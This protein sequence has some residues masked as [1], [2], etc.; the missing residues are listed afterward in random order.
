MD[1]LSRDSVRNGSFCLRVWL[2]CRDLPW[3]GRSDQPLPGPGFRNTRACPFGSRFAGHDTI[4]IATPGCGYLSESSTGIRHN[5]KGHRGRLSRFFYNS[6]SAPPGFRGDKSRVKKG[7]TLPLAGETSTADK[8]ASHIDP[9]RITAENSDIIGPNL[10]KT[11]LS[12]L[13][14]KPRPYQGDKTTERSKH[15]QSTQPRGAC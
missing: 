3:P 5:P 13:L 4:F 14:V 9:Q 11:G 7:L 10:K 1:A 8:N 6:P 15:G 2:V 12:A